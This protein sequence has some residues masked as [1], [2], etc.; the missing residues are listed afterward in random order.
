MRDLSPA[1]LL[2]IPLI[3]HNHVRTKFT[4]LVN[5]FSIPNNV[6]REFEE[7]AKEC[8]FAETASKR[9]I[10]ACQSDYHNRRSEQHP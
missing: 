4:S 3:H 10:A 6:L 8:P 1:I 7:V 5:S 9:Q 2:Y